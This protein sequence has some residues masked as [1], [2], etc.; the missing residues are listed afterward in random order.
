VTGQHRGREVTSSTVTIYTQ[1]QAEAR[2]DELTKVIEAC[3]IINP[4]FDKRAEE[5]QLS[6][7]EQ[8]LLDRWMELNF[9]LTGHH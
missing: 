6:A 2:R 4:G 8:V 9:L 7:I 5:Y 1:E 3:E